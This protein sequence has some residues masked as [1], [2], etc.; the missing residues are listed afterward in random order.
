MIKASELKLDHFFCLTDCTGIIQH[1]KYCIPDFA[2]GYTTDDNARALIISSMLY[3][4]YGDKQFIPL[5]TR[6]LS[7]LHYGQNSKGRW[8]NFM[9]YQRRFIEEEGS[10][11]SFGR[12]LWALGYLHSVK[13]LPKGTLELAGHLIKRAVPNVESLTAVRARAYSIIGLSYMCAYKAYCQASCK[14]LVQYSAN[15]LV[16]KYVLHKSEKWK[17]FED[18]ITYAN[19]IL[20][21]SLFK[22]YQTTANQEYLET[23]LESLAFLEEILMQDGY[24]KLI[25]CNG[26]AAKGEMPAQF[27]E[28]PIDAA[29]MVLSFAE[30]YRVTGDKRYINRA[31]TSFNWFLGQNCHNTP[32]INPDTGG[33]FD[34]L[35]RT[36][37]NLNQGAESLFA[38]IVSHLT[39][40]ELN[41]ISPSAKQK[42]RKKG[43]TFDQ[44]V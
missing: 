41:I 6:Y 9:S 42:A 44:A 20:P 8:K 12:S 28:Q 39:A 36:G 34:G 10:E 19:G 35:T 27:D 21:Y 16:E 3:E 38:Y 25:G 24:L 17:W 30:A 23:A 18:N 22:A 13:N 11:D 31:E 37:V 1:C 43:S 14:K 32:L 40:D 7:F 4:K 15:K 26:W 5:V 29:D 2:T 33:C